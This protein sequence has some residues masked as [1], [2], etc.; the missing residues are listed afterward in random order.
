MGIAQRVP[1]R[2]RGLHELHPG[3][4]FR[5]MSP[6]FFKRRPSLATRCCHYGVSIGDIRRKTGLFGR[7]GASR[8][9]LA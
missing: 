3:E 9:G 5:A 4:G 7:P 2:G 6:D 1:I 8:F